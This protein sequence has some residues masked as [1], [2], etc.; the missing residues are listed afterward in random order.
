[1]LKCE[2]GFEIG[3]EIGVVCGLRG[4]LEL[5]LWFVNLVDSFA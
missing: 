4:I 5:E 3:F 2:I 1:V